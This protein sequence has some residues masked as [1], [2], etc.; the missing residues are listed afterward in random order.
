MKEMRIKAWNLKHLYEKMN[1]DLLCCNSVFERT[2]CIAICRREILDKAEELKSQR[3]LTPGEVAI[4]N[5]LP[6]IK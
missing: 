4:L 3:K 5:Q 2:N 1:E 6:Y